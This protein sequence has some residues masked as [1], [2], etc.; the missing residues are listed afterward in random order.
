MTKFDVIV[1]EGRGDWTLLAIKNG[2]K[3]GRRRWGIKEKD[4]CEKEK[5]KAPV[6]AP[7][8]VTRVGLEGQNN[9]L[10]SLVL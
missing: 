7:S 1:D 5:R 4:I 10:E 9:T 6:V 2:A 3:H 8:Y